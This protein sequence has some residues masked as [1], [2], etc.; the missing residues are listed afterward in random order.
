LILLIATIAL[1]QNHK[2]IFTLSRHTSESWYPE[3]KKTRFR[4]STE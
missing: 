3:I 2:A 4:F 1:F